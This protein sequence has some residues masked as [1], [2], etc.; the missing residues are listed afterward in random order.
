MKNIIPFSLLSIPFFLTLIVISNVPT[1]SAAD[2]FTRCLVEPHFVGITTAEIVYYPTNISY[3]SIFQSSIQNLRFSS[4]STPRPLAIVTPIDE[5][6]IQIFLGCA[7]DF[8]VQVRIRGNGHDMEGL[9]YRSPVPF[10]LIDL[11]NFRDITVDVANRTA[12]VQ[13]GVTVSELYYRIAE[14]SS[15]LGF[16]GST[17]PSVGIGGFL[18]GGG[19]GTLMRKYGLGCD[20]VIDIRFMDKNG[21]IFTDKQSIGDDVFW[22]V[23]GG[24]ASN[25]G[26]VLAWQIKLV[27]VPVTVTV[28]NV[29]RTLEQNATDL[30]HKYQTFAP[31]TDRNLFIRARITPE[32]MNAIDGSQKTVAVYFQAL[33]LGRA[34]GVLKIMQNTFRELDLVKRDCLEMSWAKSALWFAGDVGF[35]K[36]DSLEQLL[37]RDLAPKLYVKAKSDFVQEPISKNGLKQ[38]WKRLMEIEQGA[39]SLVMTPYGG[40]MSTLSE[41]ATPF[42]HRIGN[43]YMIFQGIYWNKSTPVET[44]NGRLAWLR[45]LSNDLTPYVSSNPR[46][47]YVNYNDLDLGVGNST[48]AEASI[49]GTRYFNNNFKRLVQLKNTMDA[50]NFYLHEQSVPPFAL[51]T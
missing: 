49:W 46:R 24:I 25:F 3:T 48:Y 27:P 31:D 42:P 26:I 43:L 51:T 1:S 7:R 30:V 4:P 28:F 35:P 10:L 16:P 50:E 18:S 14:K 23:R 44:Q 37:N 15:T 9:S 41:G 45:R 13:A 32:N 34:S 29:K 19:Y 22:A 2:N 12:W 20:N 21:N 47:S 39:T 40:K 8:A 6:Q 11:T 33:Y 38:I 5:A 36:G 17:W